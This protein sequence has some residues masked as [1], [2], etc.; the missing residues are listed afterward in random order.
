MDLST[1]P[2]VTIPTHL[3]FTAI[4]SPTQHSSVA[5]SI[6]ASPILTTEAARL[7]E[8]GYF[9]TAAAAQLNA[10]LGAH[11]TLVG[12]HPT[13]TGAQD[14]LS[15]DSSTADLSGMMAKDLVMSNEMQDKAI[16]IDKWVKTPYNADPAESS[17]TP[18]KSPATLDSPR[19]RCSEVKT[20]RY[21]TT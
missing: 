11:Q 3:A 20:S 16:L 8:Q 19:T 4:R 10:A 17:I 18:S 7:S 6:A 13:P 15:T 1:Y 12:D 2:T 14:D 9:A 21:P 5:P